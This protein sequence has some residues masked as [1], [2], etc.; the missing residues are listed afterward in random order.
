MDIQ[1]PDIYDLTNCNLINNLI[2]NSINNNLEN[3]EYI[4]FIFRSKYDYDIII[5]DKKYIDNENINSKK[6]NNNIFFFAQ[7]KN[8]YNINDYNIQIKT[9]INGA[10]AFYRNDDE[11]PDETMILFNDFITLIYLYDFY[12]AHIIYTRNKDNKYNNYFEDK[13]LLIKFHK[14][15]IHSKYTLDFANGLI[16][17]FISQNNYNNCTRLILLSIIPNTNLNI[18][19]NTDFT[20]EY[21]FEKL[22][23]KNITIKLY[24]IKYYSKFNILLRINILKTFNNGYFILLTPIKLLLNNS[25]N[26]INEINLI[27]SNCTKCNKIKSKNIYLKTLSICETHSDLLEKKALGIL[28]EDTD[29][30]SY[31]INYDELAKHIEKE[32]NINFKSKFNVTYFS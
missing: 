27:F 15:I 5:N 30:I 23:N 26:G 16:P 2:N 28:T 8:N 17:L 1:I 3:L 14:N 19:L 21:I 18:N 13:F 11:Y 25:T 22:N 31:D 24:A 12:N 4:K 9:N 32:F 29:Y 7:L 10:F 6:K 20:Y